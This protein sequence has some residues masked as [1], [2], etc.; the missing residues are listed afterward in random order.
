M[1][2][3]SYRCDSCQS[4]ILD[5]LESISAEPIQ[6]CPLCKKELSL[7][8]QITAPSIRFSGSGWYKNGYCTH[9]FIKNP[10]NT[11]E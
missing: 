9:D 4:F 8:R 6:D 1:P 11:L 10:S 3:Y 5:K 2:L 7:K